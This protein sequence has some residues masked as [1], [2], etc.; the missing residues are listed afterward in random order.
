MLYMW[1]RKFCDDKNKKSEYELYHKIRDHYHYTGKFIGAAHNVCKLQYKVTKKI[2]I[3]FH[4][5]STCD[6]HFVS[7]Q[8]AKQFKGEFEC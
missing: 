4:N 3:V 7:K 6:Y 5:G 1:K 2:P 8:W